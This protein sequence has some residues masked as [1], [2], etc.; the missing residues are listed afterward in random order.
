MEQELGN[1]LFC[2]FSYHSFSQSISHSL[3]VLTTIRTHYSK[4]SRRQILTKNSKEKR[5]SSPSLKCVIVTHNLDTTS[6]TSA[7][8]LRLGNQGSRTVTRQR[9]LRRL[10]TFCETL[11]SS[12]IVAMNGGFDKGKV[13]FHEFLLNH[14][15]DNPHY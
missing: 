10:P 11:M 12:C 1:H 13:P 3:Q 4:S 2:C 5:V 6:P 8:R 14:G 7:H 9:H 15:R